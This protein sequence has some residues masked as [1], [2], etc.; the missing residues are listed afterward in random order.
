MSKLTTI[1]VL[2][3]T[4]DENEPPE[5]IAEAVG[6]LLDTALSTEGVLDDVGNPEVGTLE[7]SPWATEVEA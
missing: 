7:V 2:P 6:R 3:V 1:F 4:H 5:A